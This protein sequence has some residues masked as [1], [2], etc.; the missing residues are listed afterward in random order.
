M[1]ENIS[2]TNTGGNP[3]NSS[4]K[5][6]IILVI[7]GI[8]II[9]QGVKIYL[10]HQE[11]ISTENELA[12]T[13]ED[14]ASTMQQLSDI[15]DELNVKIQEIE[16]LGGNVEELEQA[17]AEIEAELANTTTRNRRALTRLQE[18]VSG[19]EVLLKAKDEEIKKLESI[20]EELLTENTSLKSEKNELSDSINTISRSK[21]ELISKVAIASQ[22]KAENINVLAVNDRGKERE[23]PF[24][25]RQIDKLKVVFNIAENKV[26][27][28]EGKNVMIRIVDPSG[29][30]IFDVDRGSGTFMLNNKEEFYTA[31]QEILFDNSRQQ[32]TF[33]YAKGSDF[34]DGSYI[35]EVYTD[36]YLM[37]REEFV[38]K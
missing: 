15:R 35:L 22:L 34:E 36:D 13:E 27:P 37:G 1:S 21:D 10:D 7:F 32:L 28:I 19:Y 29:Q 17:K 31:N 9:A 33:E 5:Y 30:V 23:S 24:R 8:I 14:L 4:R 3:S 26:A 16:A 18:K 6:I 25:A 2:N 20:N 12:T 38:V 11:R